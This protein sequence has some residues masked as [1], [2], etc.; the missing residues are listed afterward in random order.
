MADI[1]LSPVLQVI[2]DRLASPILRTIEDMFGFEDN[3]KRLQDSLSMVQAFLEDSE[4]QQVTRKAVKTWLSR[5]RDA[6]LETEDLLDHL[7]ARGIKYAVRSS[8][9]ADQVR[10]TLEAL[11]TTAME[12]LSLNLS[13]CSGPDLQ[14]DRRETSSFAVGLQVYGREDDSEK[15]IAHLLSCEATQ[16]GYQTVIPIIGIGKTTLAQLAYNDKR[17]PRCF[18]VKIWVFV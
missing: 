16:E 18:D 15:N 3:L 6:A 13:D 10:K 11:E 4:E 2:F 14:Y 9:A 5:L 8:E 17:V 1:I 12:G 7:A